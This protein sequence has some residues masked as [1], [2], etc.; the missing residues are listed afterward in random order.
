MNLNDIHAFLMTISRRL[1]SLENELGRRLLHRT[2]R[3][4]ALTDEGEEF[5]PYARS[6]VEAE[7]G[8]LHLFSLENHGAVGQL[9]ITAPSGFGNRTIV[10][11]LK[12]LFDNNP[13]IS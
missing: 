13:D 12:T 11:I 2:T 9:R 3:A 4:V 10:P 5:L 1:A 7:Q 6:M 8:A